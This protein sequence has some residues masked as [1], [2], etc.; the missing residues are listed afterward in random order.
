LDEFVAIMVK[1]GARFGVTDARGRTLLHGFMRHCHS[2]EEKML[3]LL[4]EQGVDP[5]QTDNQG[6][7]I[8]H[9]GATWFDHYGA[10]EKLFHTIT[11]L[12]V[13]SR[14]PNNQGR[15]PLHVMCEHD[16]RGLMDQP[17]YRYTNGRT[18]LFK[19]IIDQSRED[20]N[21][22]DNDSVLPLHILSTFVS[23]VY[24]SSL[25]QYLA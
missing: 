7:T 2:G 14:K 6:D 24:K 15:L 11:A 9:E 10:E 17:S 18:T 4:V 19:Y 23:N 1:A 3:K 20:I 13:D 22:P 16:Q 12:C 5:R 21:K 8:W 25:Y